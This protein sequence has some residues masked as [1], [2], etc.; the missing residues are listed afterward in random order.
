MDGDAK[1]SEYLLLE[2]FFMVLWMCSA[3][4][5]ANIV[6]ATI[7]AMNTRIENETEP[8]P[9]RQAKLRC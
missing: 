1:V 3:R 6:Q 8:T 9:T 2:I 5:H 4:S 7:R